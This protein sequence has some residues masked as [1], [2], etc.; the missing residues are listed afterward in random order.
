[1]AN[2]NKGFNLLINCAIAT[3]AILLVLLL[4]DES[5]S[6]PSWLQV[7]GR[8]HPLVLHFPIVLVLLVCW[9]ALAQAIKSLPQLL[10]LQACLPIAALAAGVSALSGFFLSREDGYASEAVQWHKYGGVALSWL[11]LLWTL[12]QSHRVMPKVW[13]LVAG[14]AGLILVVTVGHGGA[15]LT[16]GDD[17]LMAPIQKPLVKPQV[18]FASALVFQDMVNPI[19][20]TKC[21]QCH[22]AQ[23]TKGDL[24]M[25]AEALLLKGGKSG[26]LWDLQQPGFGLM[27]NRIHLPDGDKKHMP[28]I[29]KPQLTPQEILVIEQ[30]LAKGASFTL[31]VATLPATDTLHQMATAMFS[32]TATD[33]YDFAPADNQLIKKLNTANRKVAALAQDEPAIEVSFFGPSAFQNSQL[34]ELLAIK[35]Q[36][37]A[38]NLTRM[39]VGDA[40][41]ATIA[42]FKNL[43]RLN[44]SFTN[45]G[46]AGIRQLQQLPHLHTLTVSG[47][48]MS[49]QDFSGFKTFKALKT[50]QAWQTNISH[51]QQDGV[52]KSLP[53]VQLYWGSNADTAVL[54]LN[55]PII[56]NEVQVITEPIAL[57]LKHYMPATSLHYT[58]DGSEPDSI[59][60]PRY[61]AEVVISQQGLL[62]VKAFKKGWQSSDVVETYFYKNKFKADSITALLPP[63]NAYKGLGAITLNN[64]IKGDKNFRTDKWLGYKTNAMAV[65]L[66]FK[67]PATVSS[68]TLSSLVDIGSYIMPPLSIEVWG[69]ASPGSLKLLKRV[70]PTQPKAEVPLYLTGFECNFN[71]TAVQCIKIVAVPVGNLPAWHRGKGDKGWLF[72]DEIFVN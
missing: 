6:I 10:N 43:R 62:K 16:H 20:E 44:L 1:M 61:D 42:Q 34:A 23:K 38:L 70:Q 41:V 15:S 47:I 46:A 66:Q 54:K 56:E 58:L 33:S 26:K 17:F 51:S 22:N 5:V 18:A 2:A 53:G 64:N 13:N 19:L 57:K 11:L 45:V 49:A 21:L 24:M 59:G 9:A 40:D 50:L 8:M 4:A 7:A 63:D 29:G 3:N 65:V 67:A 14:L 55:P 37:V 71:P 30:W 31:A 48:S 35:T 52:A 12:L 39:P 72:A 69:G 36:L 27:M 60:S 25:T 32:K 28:P 68:I